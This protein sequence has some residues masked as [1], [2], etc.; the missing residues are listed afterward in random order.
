MWNVYNKK[1]LKKNGTTWEP[2]EGGHTNQHPPRGVQTTTPTPTWMDPKRAK[3]TSEPKKAAT[4]TNSHPQAK[5][6]K[7]TRP[8]PKKADNQHPPATSKEKNETMTKG[9]KGRQRETRPFQSP[10]SRRHQPPPTPHMKGNKGRQREKTGNSARQDHFRALE[11]LHT[12]QHLEG[13][14]RETKETT[15]DKT[16]SATKKA[17]T[18]INTHPRHEGKQDWMHRDSGRHPQTWRETKDTNQHPPST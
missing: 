16:T 12:N 10:R 17:A 11:G 13:K 3:T 18:A 8:E 6:D 15:G 7:G 2:K 9:N 4:P 1:C 5:G 14:Q